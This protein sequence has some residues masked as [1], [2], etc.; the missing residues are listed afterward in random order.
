MSKKIIDSEKRLISFS[1]DRWEIL[2]R[3]MKD[4]MQHSI[5]EAIGVLIVKEWQA[6][7]EKQTKRPAGRPKKEE[8]AGG[9]LDWEEEYKDDLPKNLDWG[10]MKIG[11][12]EYAERMRIRAEFTSIK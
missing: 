2:Q 3:M 12:Q 7:N 11:K 9:E 8:E 4:D 1:K 6:R 10:G 5:S